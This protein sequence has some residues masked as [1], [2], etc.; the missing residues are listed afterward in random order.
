MDPSCHGSWF[1]NPMLWKRYPI[2]GCYH[3]IIYNWLV[4]GPPLWKIWK[5]VGMMT[6]PIYA[7]IK[8]GNQTTKQIINI[9]QDMWKIISIYIYIYPLPIGSMYAI[10]G[11]IYHQYT[12]VLLASIYHT[13]ILWVM[14]SIIISSKH[15]DERPKGKLSTAPAARLRCEP[16]SPFTKAFDKFLMVMDHSGWG[17]P[18]ICEFVGL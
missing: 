3:V 4:V 7:K 10:Y 5:S 1:E 11:N 8:N 14:V 2:C 13:W 18:V 17:P 9:I 6:F 16:T 12:P 15:V